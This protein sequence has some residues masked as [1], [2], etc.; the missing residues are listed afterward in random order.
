MRV[1]RA[2][3]REAARPGKTK[4]G[5]NRSFSCR[6]VGRVRPRKGKEV[7]VCLLRNN[8]CVQPAFTWGWGAEGGPHE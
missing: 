8:P 6:E 2:G 1:E 5:G 4:N 7:S 3:L